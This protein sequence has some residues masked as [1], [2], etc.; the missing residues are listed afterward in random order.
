M[1]KLHAFA[2]EPSSSS[3]V[4]TKIRLDR[5]TDRAH[6]CCDNVAIIGKAMSMTCTTCGRFRGWFSAEAATF[7]IE[8]RARFGAP[9]SIV[10]RTPSRAAGA[11]G[12]G[13]LTRA[14]KKDANHGYE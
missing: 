4:G 8:T 1:P 2:T 13:S 9:E 5:P 11:G 3:L 10:L 12:E 6:G 14:A 7:I